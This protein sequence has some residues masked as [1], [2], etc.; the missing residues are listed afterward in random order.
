M[1]KEKELDI[2]F[3]DS[4]LKKVQDNDKEAIKKLKK[5]ADEGNV[6]RIW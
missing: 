1:K 2:P 4:L 5:K 3:E 6:I